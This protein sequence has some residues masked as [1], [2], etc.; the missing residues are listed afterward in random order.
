MCGY[1]LVVVRGEK[2]SFNGKRNRKEKNDLQMKTKAKLE[3]LMNKVDCP[4]DFLL[5]ER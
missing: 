2:N 1:A 4:T 3:K 5:P